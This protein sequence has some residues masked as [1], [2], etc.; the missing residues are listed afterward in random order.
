MRRSLSI[1]R[2]ADRVLMLSVIAF[3][4]I[5]LNQPVLAKDTGITLQ[6]SR[7]GY[8]G[9]QALTE[10]ITDQLGA[11]ANTDD[12][13]EIRQVLS[14]LRDGDILVLSLHSNP[15]DFG[16]GDQAVNW[17]RFWEHF[18]IENPPKLAAVIVGGCMAREY[19]QDEETHYVLI[20]ESE[21]NFIRRNLNAQVLFVPSGEILAAV[22]INDT[23]G[24]LRS[25]LGGKR[26]SKINL[27]GR[28]HYVTAPGLNRDNISLVDLRLSQ[29]VIVNV[30]H[31]SRI[32]SGGAPGD[33]VVWWEGN[34]KFP[35]TMIYRPKPGW[36]CPQGGCQTVRFIFHK[37][38]S[39]LT[40]KGALWCRG[41]KESNFFDYEVLLIDAEGRETP[42]MLAGFNCIV[43]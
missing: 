35:V 4:A 25:I 41:Y 39:A 14:Q 6:T 5:T 11:T 8:A 34:P 16:I 13:E 40:F 42:A 7:G 29:F 32:T 12:V 9:C 24:L 43:K 1:F 3:L 15:S 31:P 28:W 33:L 36:G 18:G 38:E 20:N 2:V 19:K 37:R 30:S 26:L 21:Q 22:A 23:N 27:Q 17:G 10:P